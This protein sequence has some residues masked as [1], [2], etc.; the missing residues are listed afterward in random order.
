MTFLQGRKSSGENTDDEFCILGEEIIPGASTEPEV[1]WLTKDPP[2]IIDNHFSVPIGKTDLL[3][4]PKNF[5]MA[6]LR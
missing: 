1:R 4:P 3:K 5:P 6:V 2:Y